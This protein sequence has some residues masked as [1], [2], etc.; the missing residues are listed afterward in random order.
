MTMKERALPG[1]VVEDEVVEEGAEEEGVITMVLWSTME[2]MALM[3]DEVMEAEDEV[4][5]EAVAIVAVEGGMV[6][7]VC[8]RNSV[9]II[10]MV[11]T[12]EKG[13]LS[14]RVVDEGVDGAGAGAGD[15]VVVSDQMVQSRQLPEP[16]KVE[17]LV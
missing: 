8:N 11:T 10:T 1:C 15:V 17:T 14:H 3:V 9:V 2:M 5:E 16:D 13:H 6:E 12:M 4:L 7:G